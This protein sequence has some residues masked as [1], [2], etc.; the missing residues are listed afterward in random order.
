[1]AKKELI[2]DIAGVLVTNFSPRFWQALSEE[3]HTPYETLVQ[4]GKETREGEAKR[5]G[6]NTLLAD[7]RGNWV[8]KITAQ[9]STAGGV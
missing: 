5:L 6:W 8:P 2:L 7:E 1:V 3:F 4:F 9:L